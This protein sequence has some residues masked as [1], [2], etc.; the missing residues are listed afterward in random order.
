MGIMGIIIYSL[1][2]F[3]KLNIKS[4]FVNFNEHYFL[5]VEIKLVNVIIVAND[6]FSV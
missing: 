6:I 4:V 2:V 1:F 5:P 3:I